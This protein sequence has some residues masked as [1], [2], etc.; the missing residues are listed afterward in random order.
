MALYLLGVTG[1]TFLAPMA[2]FMFET[3]PNEMR[4]Y[5]SLCWFRSWIKESM[6]GLEDPSGPTTW[7][8]GSVLSSGGVTKM[9]KS[10]K[11]TSAK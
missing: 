5:G 8:D 1:M 7:D 11:W 3:M 6:D 2:D 9:V 10:P 4:G